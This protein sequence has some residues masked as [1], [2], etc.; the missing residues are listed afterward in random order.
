MV[1]T[2]IQLGFADFVLESPVWYRGGYWVCP[3]CWE[4]RWE[5][6]GVVLGLTFGVDGEYKIGRC[7]WCGYWARFDVLMGRTWGT[8]GPE[9]AGEVLEVGRDEETE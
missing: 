3:A 8:D 7:M 5:E 6:L 4:R 2:A 1:Q 9:A